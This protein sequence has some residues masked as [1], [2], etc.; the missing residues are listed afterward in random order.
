[1][2]ISASISCADI[3]NLKKSI[4]DLNASNIDFIHYDVVDGKFNECFILGDLLLS[5]I[6]PHTNLPIEVHLAVMEPEIYIGPFIRAGADYIAIHRE[7]I[8]DPSLL[9]IIREKGAKPILAYRADTKPK[10]E[11]VELFKH[12]DGILKLTVNPGF[13]G[14]TFQ[15]E[16]LEHIKELR[17]IMNDDGLDLDIQ[18]DGNI[19]TKTVKLA[20]QAGATI[21]T[22]GTSGLFRE[23]QTINESIRLLKEEL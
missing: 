17:K 5:K 3:L 9:N 15:M 12:V 21:V 6:R 18:A 7:V 13:S 11:D 14:Q 19:N 2:K 8:S 20:Y 10:P 16:T 23:G 22:G 4:D 1:M